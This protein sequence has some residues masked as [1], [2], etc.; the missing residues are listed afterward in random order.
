VLIPWAVFNLITG[1]YAL[2]FGLLI[3][4]VIIL[5]I[6]QVIE[7]KL[8]AGQLGLPPFLTLM[9][10][11]I[12]SQLFGFF[13]IF[14]LPLAIITIKALNDEGIIHL[15]RPMKPK[16]EAVAVTKAPDAPAEKDVNSND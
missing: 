3:V 6:R 16:T 11:Y 2:G 5:V 13:G 14:L 12:G 1:N 10:M 15:Y 8:V 4:Y 9:A 7:P